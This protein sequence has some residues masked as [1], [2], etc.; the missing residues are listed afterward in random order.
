MKQSERRDKFHFDCSS[1]LLIERVCSVECYNLCVRS[2]FFLYYWYIYYFVIR[3]IG[4]KIKVSMSVLMIIAN[5][6]SMC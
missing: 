5:K 3:K 1:F 6:C 4:L 2:F